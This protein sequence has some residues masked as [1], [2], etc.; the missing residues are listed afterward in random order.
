MPSC[1]S[2]RRAFVAR[3]QFILAIDQGTTNTKAV[4]MA[5]SGAVVAA[6]SRPLSIAF[7]QPGWVEQDAR[8]LW[9]SVVEAAN[10]C[11]EQVT[12]ADIAAVGI[13]N[14]RE[15]VVVWNRHSGEPVG[16][17]VSWQC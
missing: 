16:P 10:A 14:Q 8:E 5:R 9:S 6:A 13:T 12:D 4:L 3:N 1:N 15:S 11:I 17:C 2:W 7:P